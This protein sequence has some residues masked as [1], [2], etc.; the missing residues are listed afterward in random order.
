MPDKEFDPHDPFD[1]VGTAVP[2]EDGRDGVEEMAEA[3]IDEY[4]TMGWT[5]KRILMTFQSSFFRGPHIVYRDR[6]VDYIEALISATRKR[7]R[8]R[9][10]RFTEST[11]GKEA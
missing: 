6:G 4:M 11:N 8:A 7:H 2:L 1:L 3:F 5:D 9:V 10:W